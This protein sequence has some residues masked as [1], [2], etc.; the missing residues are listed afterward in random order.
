MVHKP[1]PSKLCVFIETLILRL[2]VVCLPSACSMVY[3]PYG[4]L[5]WLLGFEVESL[6]ETF[7]LSVISMRL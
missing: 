2:E 5:A 6:S 3:I 7:L 4:I 1:T